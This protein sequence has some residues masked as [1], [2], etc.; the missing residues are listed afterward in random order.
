MLLSLVSRAFRFAF[1]LSGEVW[2]MFVKRAWTLFLDLFIFSFAWL[3][4][5][6][7]FESV[8]ERLRIHFSGAFVCHGAG[9]L[10]EWPNR[11]GSRCQFVLCNTG[12]PSPK[13][14]ILSHENRP[15]AIDK[16][17]QLVDNWLCNHFSSRLSSRAWIG[18][19]RD[20]KWETNFSNW[21]AA[22]NEIDC[23]LW[24]IRQKSFWLS[25]VL[26]PV[27]FIVTSWRGKL[28]SAP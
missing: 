3:S 21:L 1:L 27:L 14:H 8:E 24:R 13:R 2:L 26:A 20:R 11:V 4:F 23:T 28:R 17:K 19:L 16:K 18:E 6:L 12:K 25:Y 22:G 9:R 15:Q 10:T 7:W 5:F